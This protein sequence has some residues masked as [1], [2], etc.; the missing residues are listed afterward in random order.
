V[1]QHLFDSKPISQKKGTTVLLRVTCFKDTVRPTPTVGTG[2][3]LK[4]SKGE[5]F[6]LF[7]FNNFYVNFYVGDL[8]AEIKN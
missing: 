3:F 4:V 1:L 5:I 8:G 6:D 7:D 2:T